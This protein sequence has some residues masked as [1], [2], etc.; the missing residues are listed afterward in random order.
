MNP[1]IDLSA[2]VL[3]T[4]RLIL[5]PW[6]NEDTDALYEYCSVD[7]VGQM[8]GWKPHEGRAESEA[9]LQMFMQ[10][11]RTLALEYEG[12]AI[13]SIGVESYDEKSLPEF[14]RKNCRELGFVLSRDY[15]GRGLMHE[16]IEAMLEF[17]FESVG[18]DA[19]F[20]GCFDWNDQSRRVQEKSG[21]VPYGRRTCT[22]AMGKKER[23]IVR[24]LTY[25]MWQA[26]R[27]K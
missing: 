17:L 20:C 14:D 25:E 1:K 10:G 27:V 15:W 16:A 23:L 5:R 8:A 12:K 22:T 11:R 24:L 7:G 18:L 4:K 9:V 2:T 26:S 3:R 13:G 6:R 21:F 19:V